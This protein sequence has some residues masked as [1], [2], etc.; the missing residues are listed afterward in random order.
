MFF[1]II[2]FQN[3]KLAIYI[4]KKNMYNTLE[5][6]LQRASARRVKERKKLK[7]FV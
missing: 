3:Y 7:K 6:L 4:E 2:R 5:I 1:F